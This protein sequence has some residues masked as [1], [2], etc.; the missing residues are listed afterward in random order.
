LEAAQ[1]RFVPR[2]FPIL[3]ERRG[4]WTPAAA[5]LKSGPDS[6]Y[7]TVGKWGPYLNDNMRRNR[8]AGADS[9]GPFQR[10][11]CRVPKIT[12]IFSDVGGVLLSNGWDRPARHRLVEHFKLD[13]D[14]FEDRHELVVTSFE[15]GRLSMDQYLER[16]LFYR[17]RDF[18]PEQ[19]REFMFAQSQPIAESLALVERLAAS[20]RY[21]LATLNNE[22]RELNLHRIERFALKKYF[23]VFFSSCFLGVKKPDEEIYLKALQITQRAAAECVFIDDRALNLDAPRRLGMNTVLFRSASELQEELR[24]RGVES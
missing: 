10:W 23:S 3:P 24:R 18:T 22:S 14:E 21:L 12:A 5:G 1:A 19:V 4:F 2:G 13:W 6:D 15:T 16:T 20:G 7:H 11:R 17:S 8:G 9:P